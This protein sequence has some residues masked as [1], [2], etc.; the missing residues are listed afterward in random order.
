MNLQVS[1]KADISQASK[2]CTFTSLAKY[3]IERFV[4][5]SYSNNWMTWAA[6]LHVSQNDKILYLFLRKAI[7][8][9]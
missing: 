1:T 3:L 5:S 6:N 8:L 9:F 2:V 7:S 4:A